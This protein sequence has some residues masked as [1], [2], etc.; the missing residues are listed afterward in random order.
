[1]TRRRCFKCQGFRHMQADCPNR[2]VVMLFDK[3]DNSNHEDI[4]P[5]EEVN[6]EDEDA[7]VEPDE[8]DM[9][10]IQRILHAEHEDE[11]SSQREALFH[12]RYTSHGKVC[13]LIIDGGSCTN[14]VS[15]E[16]VTKLSLETEVHPKPYK[17]GC[18]QYGGGMKVTKRYLASFSIGKIYKDQIWCDVVKMDACHLLLR[19]PWQYDKRAF[20]DGYRN[21]YSFIIDGCKIVLLPLHPKELSKRAKIMSD[22]LMT[23]SH[24]IGHINKGEPLYIVVA[25]EDSQDEEHELDTRAKKLLAKFDD[26]ISEDVPLELSPMRDIQHQIDLIPGASLP[27]KEACRMNP[28]QQSELQRQVEQL[29]ERGLMRESLSPCAVPALLV[30]KKNGTWRMC[31]DS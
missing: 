23:R 28:T 7:Y 12:T 9:L 10:V 4:Q 15:E 22:M 26:V 31:V 16:M 11:K 18:L 13:S 25:M 19:I 21:T 27:N 20:H 8:G 2:K 29:L 14:A 6:E 1:M 17:V 30:P 3:E 24:I 5:I